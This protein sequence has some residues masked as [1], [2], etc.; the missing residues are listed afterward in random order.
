MTWGVFMT[1]FRTTTPLCFYWILNS[2]VFK[3]Q[4]G[5]YLTSTINQLT[6]STLENMVFPFIGDMTEQHRIHDFLEQKTSQNGKLVERELSRIELLRE[7]R[8]S[9]IS[10]VVTGKI[11]ITE[12]MV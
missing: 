6:V 10:S 1:V 11:R 2:Q 4:S 7:Y 3:S 9:L 8:Q 12:D 5:I